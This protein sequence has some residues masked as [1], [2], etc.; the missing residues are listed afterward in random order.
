MR[1]HADTRISQQLGKIQ[2]KL[3]T[4]LWHDACHDDCELNGGISR[5][6]EEGISGV[7]TAVTLVCTELKACR[8]GT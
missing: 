8:K 5:W 1:T 3:D 7:T 2:R 4:T 6:A